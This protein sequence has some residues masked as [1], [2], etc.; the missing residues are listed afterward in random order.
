MKL[1]IEILMQRHAQATKDYKALLIRLS[2]VDTIVGSFNHNQIVE[3]YKLVDDLETA[4][5]ILA[6]NKES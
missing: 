3:A 5:Y 1:S 2:G 6:T 4:L